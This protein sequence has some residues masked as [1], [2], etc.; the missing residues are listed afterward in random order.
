L[1]EV[2]AQLEGDEAVHETPQLSGHQVGI[3]RSDPFGAD[4]SCACQGDMSEDALEGRCASTH[5]DLGIGQRSVRRTGRQS[6]H[7]VIEVRVLTGDPKAHHGLKGQIRDRIIR[8]GQLRKRRTQL[9]EPAV[10]DGAGELGDPA[11]VVVDGHR[12]KPGGRRHR[13]RLDRRR[14]QLRQ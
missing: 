5:S 14:A 12:R 4:Q 6:E 9:L 2:I 11:E 8:Q 3:L 1:H 13:T 7:Q 10:D